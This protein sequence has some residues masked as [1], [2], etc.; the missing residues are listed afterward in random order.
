[1]PSAVTETCELLYKYAILVN[2]IQQTHGERQ[3]GETVKVW[4]VRIN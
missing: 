1:M 2:A 3:A 4:C